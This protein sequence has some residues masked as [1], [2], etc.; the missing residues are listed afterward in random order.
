MNGFWHFCSLS[1]I[2]CGYTHRCTAHPANRR[3]LGRSGGN[4]LVQHAGRRLQIFAG[5][6]PLACVI[7]CHVPTTNRDRAHRYDMEL[8]CRFSG[9]RCCVYINRGGALG[10][11]HYKVVRRLKRM[12]MKIRFEKCQLMRLS[13]RF[14][15]LLPLVC[16]K[17]LSSRTADTCDWPKPAA[18]VKEMNI[19]CVR[20]SCDGGSFTAV[21]GMSDVED[22]LPKDA[23]FFGVCFTC[24][25]KRISR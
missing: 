19:N 3:N 12:R 6:C 25:L 9:R 23:E 20:S 14:G 13:V 15:A 21:P 24:F 17:N 5:L 16:Q 8:L 4:A 11:V 7:S 18:G 22:F 2:K 1:Q 10:V